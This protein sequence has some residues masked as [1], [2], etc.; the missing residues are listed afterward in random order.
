M[1]TK[2]SP[3]FFPYQLE[4]REMLVIDEAAQE[5]LTPVEIS[6]IQEL[7]LMFGLRPAERANIFFVVS[8]IPKPPRETETSYQALVNG[9]ID[10]VFFTREMVAALQASGMD[11]VE[12]I[13]S[14]I[15]NIEAGWRDSPYC[16]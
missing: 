16:R 10:C 12:D 14:E 5:L 6:Q 7:G 4:V 2:D 9:K 11:V 1:A 3:E 15:Q 13:K 8:P